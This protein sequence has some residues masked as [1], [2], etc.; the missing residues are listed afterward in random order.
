MQLAGTIGQ[1][2]KERPS[3]AERTERELEKLVSRCCVAATYHSAMQLH[4]IDVDAFDRFDV[5]QRFNIGNFHGC[6]WPAFRSR[7]PKNTM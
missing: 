7:T 2:G 4:C 5:H 1:A 6:S 3:T